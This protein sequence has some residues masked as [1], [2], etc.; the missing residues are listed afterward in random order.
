MRKLFFTLMLT[1]PLS[2]VAQPH[3]HQGEKMSPEQQAV[4]KAKAL[5]LQLDLIENQEGTVKNVLENQIQTMETHRKKAKETKMSVYDRKL[6]HLE[7][8]MAL[9]EQMKSILTAEQY[10]TWKKTMAYKKRMAMRHRGSGKGKNPA[11]KK[12]R[13]PHKRG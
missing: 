8:L 2:M 13:R 5:R 7:N 11:M 12:E 3:H 4:L 6:M 1:L 10:E 9:H